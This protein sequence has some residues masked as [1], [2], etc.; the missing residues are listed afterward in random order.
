MSWGM[1]V[2]FAEQQESQ[3]LS[4]GVGP[5]WEVSRSL[6]MRFFKDHSISNFNVHINLPG[7]LLKY[8]FWFSRSVARL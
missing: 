8:R 1:L 2:V 5:A 4:E 6:F 3:K 7:T